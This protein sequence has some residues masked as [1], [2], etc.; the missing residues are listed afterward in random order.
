MRFGRHRAAG[1]ARRALVGVVLGLVASL[2]LGTATSSA[3]TSPPFW[4]CRASA[5]WASLADNNRIEPV[6]ANGNPNTGG[7][8]NPDR[9]QCAT[10]E[11]GADNLAT[12]LGIPQSSIAAKSAS[13]KTTIDPEY[14]LALDQNVLSEAKIENL[15]LG[16][17][18]TGPPLFVGAAESSATGTCVNGTPTLSGTSKLTDIRLG[19]QSISLDQLVDQLSKALAPLGPI[20]DIK[21]NEQVKS[22]GSLIVRALHV[23]VFR[24]AAMGS[25]LLDVIVAE[26]KVANDADVCNPDKQFP[27]RVC[28]KG[29]IFEVTSGLCVIRETVNNPRIVVGAA[30]QGPN[31]PS[32]GCT[33][34][35][36]TEARKKYKSPCLSGPGPKFVIV[37]TNHRDRI[38][39]TNKRDRILGLGGNDSLD[40]GRGE[41]CIDGGTGNDR[42]TGGIGSD[43]IYGMAGNDTLT[44]NL[45]NDRIYGGNGNDHLNGGPG[46]DL[47]VGGAGHDTLAAGYGRDR[48]LGGPGDDF[49]NIAQQ[50]PAASANCGSGRDKIRLNKKEVRRVVGCEIEYV[51]N[52]K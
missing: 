5:L 37:G 42:V 10:E 35:P 30:F 20:V 16:T 40:G 25:P 12:P 41:D 14:G 45:D 27:F 50:G 52:D 39:G 43:R 4:N 1:G 44:G 22:A 29:S 47:L 18:P 49:V 48:V 21:V 34:I 9:A 36:L 23:K 6:L 15:S 11:D 17:G 33:V 24:D 32:G 46:A 8:K 7:K 31:C 28:P 19:G 13:A 2:V 26:S 3:F 51:L 38:T